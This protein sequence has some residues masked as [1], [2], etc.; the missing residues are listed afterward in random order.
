M[1][2]TEQRKLILLSGGARASAAR[3]PYRPRYQLSCGK[4][5]RLLR[6]GA[7]IEHYGA[8]GWEEERLIF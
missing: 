5:K 4:L 6:P 2:K 8:N 1:D 7:F 3:D